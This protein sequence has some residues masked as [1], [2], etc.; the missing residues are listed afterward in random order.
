MS[1]GL[2][3]ETVTIDTKVYTFQPVLTNVDGNVLIGASAAATIVNLVAAVT[4]GSG[5]GT[6]Y[7]ADMVTHPTATAADG[8]GDTIDVTALVAGLAGNVDTTETMTNGSF[9][10]ATLINGTDEDAVTIGTKVYTFQTVLTNFDGNVLI[11]ANA[12][13]TIVNLVAAIL[14]TPGAGTLYADFMTKHPDVVAADGTGDT[15][16]V[17]AILPGTPGNAIATTE[18]LAN[19]SFGAVTLENGV[20][21]LFTAATNGIGEG[22]GPYHLTTSGTLPAGLALATDYWIDP[23][24]ADDFTLSLSKG[25]SKSI[26]SDTGSGTHTLTKGGATHDFHALLNSNKSQTIDAATDID[27]LA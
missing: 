18:T 27:D 6:L 1:G 17:T 10:N 4:L 8:T 15:V 9:A 19:G 23:I 2:D 12:A 14:L 7:A 26:T 16:D 13:A 24:D 25:G 5:S 11:G 22:E 3:N 20:D 21:G